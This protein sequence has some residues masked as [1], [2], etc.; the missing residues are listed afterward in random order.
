MKTGISKKIIKVC[1]FCAGLIALLHLYGILFRDKSLD[2]KKEPITSWNDEYVKLPSNSLDVLFL[3]TSHNFC[4]INPSQ[5]WNDTGI[6]SYNFSSSAQDVNASKAYLYEGLR[7]QKPK[8]VFF[9]VRGM[10]LEGSEENWNRMAYD[11]LPFSVEKYRNV[12][13]SIQSDQETDETLLSY[14][15]PVFRYHYRWDSLGY[16]DFAYMEPKRPLQYAMLGYYPRYRVTKV[17]LDNFYEPTGK[18]DIDEQ[19]KETVADMKA[20][21]N[22]N[23]IDF[24]LWKAPTP[25]WREEYHNLVQK[26]ADEWDLPFLDLNYKIKEIDID[27]ESDFFDKNSHLNSYGAEK[28]TDFLE[29]YLTENYAFDDHRMDERYEYWEKC[30]R[31]FDSN[32]LSQGISSIEDYLR[33]VKDN[34]YLVFFAVNDGM[35]E[36][37]PSMLQLLQEIGFQSDFNGSNTKSFIA[38]MDDGAIKYENLQDSALTYEA[39]SDEL[40]ITINSKGY[41]AGDDGNII[42]NGTDYMVSGQR[43]LGIVVYDK[44][45]DQ[46]IDSVTFDIKDN[47]KLYRNKNILQ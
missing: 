17:S 39:V 6:T 46:V 10:T 8:M 28:V 29:R 47:K 33:Y 37:D 36:L 43:G 9:E 15:F 42:I 19:I 32:Y 12:I 21:C 11:N 27:I 7:N 41:Y 14:L 30:S 38:V 13:N 23:G 34:S 16:D 25:M 35:A 26:F 1:L 45:L 44:V 5:I 20:M 3:G 24:V 18:N 31:R 2:L 4:T 22:K 40:R